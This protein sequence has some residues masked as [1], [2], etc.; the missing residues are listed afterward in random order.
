MRTG[1][2][3]LAEGGRSVPVREFRP[4][5]LFFS[6]TDPRGVIV[7][8]NAVFVRLSGYSFEELQQHPHNI[9]R[10][11]AMPR[12]AFRLIWDE[13]QA[14]RTVAS[15]VANQAK[16][17]V[18]YEV[19]AAQ[20][21]IEGGY[22]SIRLRPEDQ[23]LRDTVFEI[24]D[25]ARAVEAATAGGAREQ[26]AAGAE[27]ILTELAAFGIPDMAAL[28][29]RTLS[30]E[31]T[32]TLGLVSEIEAPSGRDT[33][34]V[35][36]RKIHLVSRLLLEPLRTLEQVDAASSR[37]TADFASAQ[38]R[39]QLVGDLRSA[40]NEITE[41]LLFTDT[42]TSGADTIGALSTASARTA[43]QLDRMGV[44]FGEAYSR[45]SGL[46]LEVETLAQ[47]IAVFALQNQMI[48]RF[49]SELLRG[50]AVEPPGQVMRL[51]HQALAS[52]FDELTEGI[53]RVNAL[54]AAAPETIA[55][56]RQSAD[57]I[58]SQLLGWCDAAELTLRGR[59]N[60][61]PARLAEGTARVRAQAVQGLA[62]LDEIAALTDELRRVDVRIDAQPIQATL[63]FI[64]MV[65]AEID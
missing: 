51:L 1:L 52:H 6:I 42:G 37:L 4:D 10:G 55:R 57:G 18:R 30:R 59:G 27:F 48:G 16:D 34:E 43:D 19:F 17:G 9:V 46:R 41:G 47:Q 20:V 13:L 7:H 22:L 23:G 50:D 25:R 54:M 38:P 15:Y 62:W 12:G 63:K 26:A 65:T 33:L 14:G 5:E 53:D 35:L 39:A 61:A 11:P 40:L 45:V 32:A 56:A 24:F 8:A 60:A 21:P 58:E 31:V 2:M 3:A 36:L 44:G 49:A 29:R 28:T 64:G